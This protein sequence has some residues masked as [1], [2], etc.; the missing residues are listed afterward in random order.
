[1]PTALEGSWSG[2][3]T[4]TLTWGAKQPARCL[5]DYKRRRSRWW[6]VAKG[7][8]RSYRIVVTAPALDHDLSLL[9]GIKDLPS[10]SSSR[11]RA[12]KLSI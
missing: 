7:L 2:V 5:A 3:G 4:L 8:V 6:P 9:Q 10:K 1:V 11:R 12:L